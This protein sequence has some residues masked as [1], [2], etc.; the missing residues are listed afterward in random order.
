M[1][2]IERGADYKEKGIGEDKW[3][4]ELGEGGE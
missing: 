3:R 2:E 1:K 4:R